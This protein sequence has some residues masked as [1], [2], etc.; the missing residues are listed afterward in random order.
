MP[1]TEGQQRCF[2]CWASV[3]GGVGPGTQRLGLDSPAALEG[4]S[5]LGGPC[6]A[7]A[8]DCSCGETL[9]Q[10]QGTRHFLLTSVSTR[11]ANEAQT[12]I[13]VYTHFETRK[14]KAN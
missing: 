14:I 12:Y 5:V 3:T 11:H 8:A 1:E 2:G 7:R 10:F 13:Q 6:T 4:P 9:V